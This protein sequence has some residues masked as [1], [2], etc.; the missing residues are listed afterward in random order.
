VK[1]APYDYYDPTTIAE[2]V[3]LLRE[4]GDEA[5]LLAGGQSLVPLLNFRL[6]RP[7]QLIDINGVAGLAGVRHEGD[8][9]VIGAGTRQRTLERSESLDGAWALLRNALRFV[10]HVHIRARGTV[11]GSLAHADPAGEL[12]AAVTA[13]GAR[14][15]LRG[16]R[17]QREVASDEFF[18]G[19]F[20]TA[21]AADEIL[22][23]VHI[24]PWPASSGRHGDFAQVA[25]GAAVALDDDGRVARVGVTVAGVGNHPVL[26][27][28]LADGLLGERPTA[29]LIEPL[30]ERFVATLR[31]P[32]DIHGSADYRRHLTRHLVPRVLADCVGRAT[33]RARAVEAR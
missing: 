28:E 21:L 13:L 24:P 12:P 4:F 25:V 8:T 26:A 31:P 22:T 20:T 30:T 3:A 33:T 1:P 9:L 6:A 16:P 15:V 11:G 7:S 2:T 32:S 29:E 23:E 10:G 19:V 14:V 18:Q 17:G 27:R 5:K